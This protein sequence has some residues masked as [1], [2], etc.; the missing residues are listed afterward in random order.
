MTGHPGLQSP[1]VACADYSAAKDGPL[2][3]CLWDGKQELD[4]RHFVTAG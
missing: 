2:V 4:S 3:A 1:K